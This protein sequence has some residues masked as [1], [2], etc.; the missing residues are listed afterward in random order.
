MSS[1]DR[2]VL[3]L[4]GDGAVWNGDALAAASADGA[5]RCVWCGQCG[6]E[7]LSAARLGSQGRRDSARGIGQPAVPAEPSEL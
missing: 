6:V 5:A 3:N 7:L 4:S 1:G 2:C